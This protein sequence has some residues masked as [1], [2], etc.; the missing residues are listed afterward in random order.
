MKQS[1]LGRMQR[2]SFMLTITLFAMIGAVSAQ[3]A[4]KLALVIGNS[5]YQN[6]SPLRNP[7]NDA[8]LIGQKLLEV[9][10]EV[11]KAKDLSHAKTQQLIAKF[12]DKIPDVGEDGI[13]LF[14]YAGHGIQYNGENFI[15]PVDAN[16]QT[17]TDIILQGIN[18][19]V[20]LK[21]IELAGA[22][23]NVIVLDACRNNPFVGVSRSVNNGLARMDS[24]SGS[25][26]AYSTAPGEVALD[27]K[28]KNSPYSEALAKHLTDPSLTLEQIFKK[29]RRDVYYATEKAQTTWE[30]T[31]LIDEI[32]LASKTPDQKTEPAKKP[33][34]AV[35]EENFWNQIRDKNDP[36]LFR[37]YLQLFPSGKYREIAVAQ[38]PRA[39][40][41]KDKQSQ[42]TNKFDYSNQVLETRFAKFNKIIALLTD[43]N[44]QRAIQSYDRYRSWC[45]KNLKTGPTGK[46]RYISYGLYGLY[47]LDWDDYVRTAKL[48]E[49]TIKLMETYGNK[50]ETWV[51]NFLGLP[52]EKPAFDQLDNATAKLINSFMALHPEV[53]KAE[54]YYSNEM[55]E[56]DQAKGARKIHKTLYPLFEKFI[57]SYS[58]L[59]R[60]VEANLETI[61]AQEIDYIALKNGKSW[62]WYGARENYY[63]LR[64]ALA[65]NTN[66]K[67]DK[68]KLDQAYREYLANFLEISDFATTAAHPP[69]QYADL[70]N[71]AGSRGREMKEILKSKRKRYWS[72]HMTVSGWFD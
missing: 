49:K 2:L 27:G 44:I 21:I 60:Q 41:P 6:T 50:P 48:D 66:P 34:A 32:Y 37:T 22:K 12:A 15:V 28:G 54:R 7:A 38:L 16:L 68:K 9:G 55:Y 71:Q 56:F 10:F 64:F 23:T 57:Q 30:S 52:L 47:G 13:V 33:L 36:D 26:I 1:K 14:Y 61:K 65:F 69:A 43:N 39:E 45:C 35:E 67:L 8:D 11:I 3:A 19:S 70:V 4:N 72:Q 46:E 25:L 5:A 63:L 31:S 17:D 62:A 29:V 24:P 18:T 20:V 53:Q 59:A 40:D 51:D 42:V 58:H